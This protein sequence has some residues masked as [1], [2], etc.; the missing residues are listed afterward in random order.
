MRC[1]SSSTSGKLMFTPQLY[2]QLQTQLSQWITP[3]D[4][5]HLTVFCENVAAILQSESGCLS[6][7][8]KYLS[9]RSCKARSQM[10]RLN[11]FVHNPQVTAETFYIPL[12]KKFLQA[13]T[14]MAMTLTLDTSMLWD[15][16]CLIEVCLA[17]GGRSFP[18]A[19]K[20]IEHGSAS[21]AFAD[22]CTVL[23][24]AQ[25]VL[26]PHCQVT[27]LADRGF[28]HGE[29]IRW[30]QDQRWSW[31]IR[32]KSD[33]KIALTSGLSESVATLLP[34]VGQAALYRDVTILG[35]IQCHLATAHASIAQEAWAVITGTSPSLQ[36]FELYG[37]RFGGIEPHFKDYKSAAFELTRSNIRDAQALSRLLMLLAT[38]TIISISMAIEVIAQDR[39]N[40]ID[41]HAQRGLSF[42]QIGL[43]Y[44]N[45]LCYLRLPLPPLPSL[46]RTNPP[47]ACASL[48]KQ[49]AMS[50]C[51]EFDKVT[52]F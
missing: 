10:E 50:T 4:K 28:E 2:G 17:W 1:L 5:R 33:L 39:L 47:P 41:W 6:H 30:L 12:L 48:K 23:G 20:V 7:W 9:H 18:L 36:T 19:Q 43:R 25:A 51:I 16:Y 24:T 21:V 14:G 15:E 31:A 27:L 38:A 45:R 46:P 22:Y 32:A 29:L 34:K 8:L 35:D 11:Y 26:P 13:W 37:R 3:K 44:I 42:L 52:F 40:F 49:A